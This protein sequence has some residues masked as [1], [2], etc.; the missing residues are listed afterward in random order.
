MHIRVVCVFRCF[1]EKV[2]N[3]IEGYPEGDEDEED[4]ME[5]NADADGNED[6]DGD[7]D[8]RGF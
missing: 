8:A 2:R 1:G 5:A 7:G 4:D 6:S 3:A